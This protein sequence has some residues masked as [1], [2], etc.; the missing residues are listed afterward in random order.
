MV[1]HDWLQR[2]WYGTA[3]GGWLL[4]PLSWMFRVAVNLRRILYRLGF[5]PA[6][7][8][9]RPVVVVGNVTVGGTGKTPFVL[10]LADR[11]RG[12]GLQVGIASRGYGGRGSA[13]PVEVGI[14]DDAGVVGDEPLLMARRNIASVVVCRRR[15]DAAEALVAQGADVI[16]CDDGL[17]HYHLARDVEVALVDGRRRFGNGRLLPAGPLREPESRLDRA[18]W[19]ICN[20]DRA[21]GR[22]LGMRLVGRLLHSLDDGR[23]LRIEE[24]RGRRCHAVAGIGNP[25]AFFS[26]LKES[27]LDIV[28]HPLPD[29]SEPR[30]EAIGLEASETVIMTEKDAVKCRDGGRFDAWFLPVEAELD[31][32]ADGIV[33]QVKKLCSNVKQHRG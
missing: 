10:W 29:H 4:V 18:D 13:R 22:E 19:V 32:A 26:L 31:S 6:R 17:Q 14:G 21:Q 3:R 7:T 9:A 20:G 27:G 11:L 30:L 1:L 5:L 8:V 2:V 23:V 16:V 28:P 15:A 24:F 33:D 12:E 25:A